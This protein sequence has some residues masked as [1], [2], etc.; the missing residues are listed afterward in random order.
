MLCYVAFLAHYS[1]LYSSEAMRSY[2]KGV[3]VTKTSEAWGA[4]LLRG[5]GCNFLGEC[6]VVPD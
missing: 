6:L 1:E 3:A 5:I 2:A 4:C